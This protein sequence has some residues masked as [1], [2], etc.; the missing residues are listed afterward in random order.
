MSLTK[1]SAAEL[2]GTFWLV[3]GGCGSAVLAAGI[4]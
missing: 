3:L 4:R 1:R 2:I